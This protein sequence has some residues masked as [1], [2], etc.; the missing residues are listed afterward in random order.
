MSTLV[1]QTQMQRNHFFFNGKLCYIY[2]GL[3][4]KYYTN[5]K[6]KKLQNTRRKIN[7]KS[8]LKLIISRSF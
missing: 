8:M 6:N 3:N 5:K 4:P 1:I 7:N 2:R